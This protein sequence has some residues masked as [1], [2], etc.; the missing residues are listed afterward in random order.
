MCPE[1][2]EWRKRAPEGT[3]PPP[4]LP[5]HVGNSAYVMQTAP[6][7]SP[8]ALQSVAKWV[9]GKER[10][11]SAR[12]FGTGSITENPWEPG[13]QITIPHQNPAAL[14]VESFLHRNIAPASVVAPTNATSH[15][16]SKAITQPLAGVQARKGPAIEDAAD[17]HATPIMSIGTSAS[18]RRVDPTDETCPRRGVFPFWP[19]MLEPRTGLGFS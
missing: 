16:S 19:R 9:K 10:L 5:R 15:A 8:S 4:T 14:R 11:R 3:R 18:V 2:S 6:E 1:T 12:S 13:F 7:I 17:W